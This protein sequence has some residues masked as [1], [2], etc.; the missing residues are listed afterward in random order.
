[1][2]SLVKFVDTTSRNGQK[3][4]W[5]RS[6]IDGLPFRG[7]QPPIMP[8]EEYESRAVRVADVRNG[9]FDT[10]SVEQNKQF[11]EVMECCFNGWF[12]MVYIERFWN[13]STQHY[14][15]WAEYYMEDGQ[16]T[17]FSHVQMREI[18]NGLTNL[19]GHP[20]QNPG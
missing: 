1:M 9:F 2:S 6:N 16:R 18:E 14:V 5:H 8:D 3:I 12:Q 11:C 19:L 17:P 13:G 20:G 7:P 15:E 10:T 4:W